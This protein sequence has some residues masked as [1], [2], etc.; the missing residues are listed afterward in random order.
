M[1]CNDAELRGGVP[2]LFCAQV[3]VDEVAL[4]LPH[5]GDGLIQVVKWYI[6]PCSHINAIHTLHFAPFVSLWCARAGL[7]RVSVDHHSYFEVAGIST[8]RACVMEV[9]GHRYYMAWIDHILDMFHRRLALGIMTG[10]VEYLG[11]ILHFLL[12]YVLFHGYIVQFV[13]NRM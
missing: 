6:I 4:P 8:Q 10:F 2:L 11:D 5:F 12:V 7:I 9:R 1:R 3:E 13:Q